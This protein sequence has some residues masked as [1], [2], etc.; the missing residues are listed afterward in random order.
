MPITPVVS[1]V[2]SMSVNVGAVSIVCAAVTSAS[3][4]TRTMC[5]DGA[6]S[7]ALMSVGCSLMER[8]IAETAEDKR[9]AC[10]RI[11]SAAFDLVCVGGLWL[12]NEALSSGVPL[13]NR[14]VNHA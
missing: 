4:S 14:D 5:M 13:E 2:K 10:K 12:L 3:E 11:K 7:C 6:L 8:F 1:A 9:D